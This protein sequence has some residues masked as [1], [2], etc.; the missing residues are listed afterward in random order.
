M[1]IDYLTVK[2]KEAHYSK[3]LRRVDVIND[4]FDNPPSDLT[5]EEITKKI[6]NNLNHLEIMVAQDFWTT[7]DMTSVNNAISRGNS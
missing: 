5:Q 1:T 6:D 3:M 4:L 7:E 2:T